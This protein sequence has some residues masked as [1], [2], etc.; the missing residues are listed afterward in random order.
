MPNYFP[1]PNAQCSYQFDADILPPAAMVTCPLCRTKFPY[2]A[3]RPLP[4]P[5]PAG[6]VPVDDPRPSGPRVLTYHDAPKGNLVLTTILSVGGFVIVLIA[7]IAVLTVG[8]KPKSISTQEATDRDFNLRVEAFPAGWDDDPN[9]LRPVN[10]NIFGRKRLDPEG[11]VALAAEKWD[12]R[13]PRSGELDEMMKTRLRGAFRSVE[14]E[15]IE[16]ATWSGH[17]AN[18]VRFTGNLD[19]TQVRG[20]AHV[21]SYKGIGYVFIAWAPESSWQAVQ[22]EAAS[23]REKVKTAE[24]REKW[25]AK[26][27]NV[28]VHTVE[29]GAYQ[30][31]DLDG[32]WTRGRP[33]D[34]NNP[35]KKTDFIVDDLKG[36]DP[37]AT[38]IF[39]ARYKEKKNGVTH[40]STALVLEIP[41]GG[42]P[43]E[44]A[45]ANTIERIKRDFAGNV[46]DVKLEV[47]TKSPSGIALPT[48]GPAMARLIFRNP[49]DKE[50]RVM[51][52]I[53][54]ISV[55][56]KTIAVAAH[57][58]EVDATYLEEWM[59]RLAG[60]LKAK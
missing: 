50:D 57:C 46:P 38:M 32:A 27:S 7:I 14:M 58:Q 48:D 13:E 36:I 55:G 6:G 33:D 10:A 21:I 44:A 9:T 39:R 31:E 37:A 24:F 45:K 4:A 18:A 8:G 29:G 22:A 41:G 17:T 5:A 43:L 3:N 28:Q 23:L 47:M 40:E 30:V 35:A 59:I 1:C 60:S 26:R 20:E 12:E 34:E 52:V 15:P 54:A 19:D 53:S 16:G 56:G 49:Q 11:Y 2:R 25:V 42:D 51:H